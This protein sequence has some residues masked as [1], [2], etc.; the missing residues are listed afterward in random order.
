MTACELSLF[1][2]PNSFFTRKGKSSSKNPASHFFG[3]LDG[4]SQCD[5]VEGEDI[6]PAYRRRNLRR[7]GKIGGLILFVIAIQAIFTLFGLILL[8]VGLGLLPVT[9]FLLVVGVTQFLM[10]VFVKITDWCFHRDLD[11]TQMG[12]CEASA[13][14]CVLA[15]V[16][17]FYFSGPMSYGDLDDVLIKP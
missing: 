2:E 17:S 10:A 14:C 15:S 6:I 11:S 5:R 3:Y 7:K 9:I 13:T 8:Q 16:I 12:W 4:Q 1:S